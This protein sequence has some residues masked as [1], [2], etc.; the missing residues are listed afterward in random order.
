MDSLAVRI[1]MQA[2]FVDARDDGVA[3]T[4]QVVVILSQLTLAQSPKPFAFYGGGRR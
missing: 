4:R 1:L 3:L 2:G